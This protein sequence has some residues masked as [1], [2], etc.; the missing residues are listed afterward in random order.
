MCT[1]GQ[2]CIPVDGV[3]GRWRGTGEAGTCV[4]VPNGLD[5]TG[6]HCTQHADD[7]GCRH[8]GQSPLNYGR[9]NKREI[10]PTP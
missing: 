2:D 5:D 8:R 4:V 9:G 6:H 3:D 7:A 1:D 10:P